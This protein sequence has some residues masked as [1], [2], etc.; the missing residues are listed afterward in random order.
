MRVEGL[1]P[2]QILAVT[3]TN[4]A[5]AEMRHRIEELLEYPTR[6][7]W[8]GTFHGLAHRLLRMHWHEAGL[9]EGFQIMDSEDQ[10]RMIRRLLKML[11]L[12]EGEWAP[13]EIQWFVNAQKDEGLRAADL[14]D[15]GNAGRRKMI[16]LYARYERMCEDS[17]SAS[18]CCACSRC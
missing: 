13:K 7:L 9:A 5:A 4:K 17:T 10:L 12:E 8:I 15:E 3:F 1:A 14:D 2:Q 16:E 6:H 18:S 11:G